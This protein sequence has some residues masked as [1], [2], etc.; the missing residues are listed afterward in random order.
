MPMAGRASGQALIS[1]C[2]HAFPPNAEGRSCP[3]LCRTSGR[4]RHGPPPILL[5]WNVAIT[6]LLHRKRLQPSFHDHHRLENHRS[7]WDRQQAIKMPQ[8]ASFLAHGGV[9]LSALDL[10]RTL[11]YLTAMATPL[12]AAQ[13][14]RDLSTVAACPPCMLCLLAGEQAWLWQSSGRASLLSDQG[15]CHRYRTRT[16]P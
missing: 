6:G 12:E 11:L 4:M 5:L 7:I 9:G 16:R 13:P 2:R 10:R 15:L 3:P 14:L 1:T 8:R